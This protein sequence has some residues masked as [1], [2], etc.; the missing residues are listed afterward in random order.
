MKR[1]YLPLLLLVGIV[2]LAAPSFADDITG[3][4]KILCTTI[5]VTECFADGVCETGPPEIWNMPRFTR[6]NL[7]DKTLK[8]TRASG[9]NRESDIERIEQEG[10][11]IFIQGAEGGKAFTV[12]IDLDTGTTTVA[13]ALEGSVLAGFGV[14]TPMDELQ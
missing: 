2:L 13:I 3:K 10:D 6:V 7:A 4:D 1:L 12:L 5:H 11:D 8:T 14:C 9:E